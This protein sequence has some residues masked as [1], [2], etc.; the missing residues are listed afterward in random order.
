MKFTQKPRFPDPRFPENADDLALT[1]LH[2]RQQSMQASEFPLTAYKWTQP[3]L[4][5]RVFRRGLPVHRQHFV[6]H[7]GLRGSCP[8]HQLK[9]FAMHLVLHECQSG[10]TDEQRVR[11]R[12]ILQPHG[13]GGGFSGHQSGYLL[14]LPTTA[15][16]RAPGVYT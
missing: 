13:D 8:T 9:R 15:D 10:F 3:I 11:F 5:S 12:E 16:H 14:R 1:F 4:P 7:D 6:R 2:T